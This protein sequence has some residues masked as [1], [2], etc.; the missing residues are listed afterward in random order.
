MTLSIWASSTSQ[1]LAVFAAPIPEPE[2]Y[3]TMLAGLGL[4]GFVGNRNKRR[5]QTMASR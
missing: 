1:D 2:I 5:R 3:A 4:L